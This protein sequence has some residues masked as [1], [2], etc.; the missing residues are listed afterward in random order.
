MWFFARLTSYLCEC[1]SLISRTWD[2]ARSFVLPGMDD[3][4]FRGVFRQCWGVSCALCSTGF[5]GR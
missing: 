4:A 2:G 1:L 5:G 3:G